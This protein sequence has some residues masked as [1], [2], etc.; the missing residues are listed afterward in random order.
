M[1]MN[2]YGRITVGFSKLYTLEFRT[3]FG[4][5][6]VSGEFRNYISKFGSNFR[7][8]I[9]NSE[10]QIACLPRKIKDVGE[11]PDD[12]LLNWMDSF[13]NQLDVG[14]STV[15]YKTLKGNKFRT[16]MQMKCNFI[17]I[18][19]FTIVSIVFTMWIVSSI[20]GSSKLFIINIDRMFCWKYTQF[21]QRNLL[22]STRHNCIKAVFY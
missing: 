17:C 9:W 20:L 6:Q 10:I 21:N 15:I 11:K 8:L 2:L 18:R 16:R 1:C 13:W 7:T 5:W 14:E 12:E 19:V 22:A 4:N 3:I